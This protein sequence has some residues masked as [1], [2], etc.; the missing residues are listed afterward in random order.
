MFLCDAAGEEYESDVEKAYKAYVDRLLLEM[1]HL[2]NIGESGKIADA[3][4]LYTNRTLIE[5]I[6]RYAMADTTQAQ[7]SYRRWRK[8]KKALED[9]ILDH[10]DRMIE[11]FRQPPIELS[12][13]TVPSCNKTNR[14]SPF[15]RQEPKWNDFFL[16]LSLLERNIYL[17]K[18]L[19]HL[20]KSKQI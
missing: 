10:V 17:C 15:H 13:A 6:S 14:E 3:S 12:G 20:M 4:K 16:I 7:D 9:Y 11:Y 18:D 1:A 8:L 19:P 5:N 2:P